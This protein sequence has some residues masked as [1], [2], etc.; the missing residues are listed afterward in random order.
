METVTSFQVALDNRPKSTETRLIFPFNQEKKVF[1]CEEFS[2]KSTKGLLSRKDVNQVIE[3]LEG[4][5]T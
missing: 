1:S 2:E 3:Q 4:L 5:P